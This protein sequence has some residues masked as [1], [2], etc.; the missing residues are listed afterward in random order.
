MV[1]E[2]SL[3]TGERV[4]ITVNADKVKMTRMQMMI[5]PYLIMGY[6]DPEIARVLG[7]SPHTIKIHRSKIR[8]NLGIQNVRRMAIEGL[9]RNLFTLEILR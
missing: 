5:F 1:M 7:T 6:S 3:L 8:A 2:F 9:V 4:R